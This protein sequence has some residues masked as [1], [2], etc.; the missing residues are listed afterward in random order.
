MSRPRAFVVG[1]TGYTGRA[2]VPILADQGFEVRAHI[3]PESS[4]RGRLGPRFETAGATVDT[5]PWESEAMEDTL[6]A[7]APTH[8]FALLGTT[9]KR[10]ASEGMD[11]A[12]AYE[13]VD[14]GLTVLLIHALEK[15]HPHATF[16]YLSAA[17]T[18]PSSKNPYVSARARVEATLRESALPWIVARPSLITGDREET[19]PGE[20]VAAAVAD[21][22]FRLARVLG[23][24][25]LAQRYASMT[26]HELA[27]GLA[28]IALEPE[29][30]GTI[31]HGEDLRPARKPR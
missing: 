7:F 2:L 21:G 29:R 3:R 16:I 23:A 14:C 27:Q 19:R 6:R 22:F 24:K 31:V 18:R 1:A 30:V 15:A 20:A 5:T 12:A 17:G 13:K 11:A 26:G 9:R 10:A 25:K 8:V 28:K 4:Q